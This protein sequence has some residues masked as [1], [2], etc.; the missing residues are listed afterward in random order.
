MLKTNAKA[1]RLAVGV[2]GKVKGPSALA[3]SACVPQAGPGVS[4]GP[5]P[6][7]ALPGEAPRKARGTRAP[8]IFP[9]LEGAAFA[10]RA[11]AAALT[12][13]GPGGKKEGAPQ[14]PCN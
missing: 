1:R 12:L 14:F 11:P 10:S 4:P 6:A 2:C 9:S 13:R 5:L 8:P 7:G 3:G